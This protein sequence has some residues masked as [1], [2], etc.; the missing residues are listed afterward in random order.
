MPIEDLENSQSQQA[1]QAEDFIAHCTDLM[2][3]S[4]A[5]PSEEEYE[6]LC[7]C[8]SLARY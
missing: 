2:F 8:A 7:V 5:E 6:E 4:S 3:N 1:A